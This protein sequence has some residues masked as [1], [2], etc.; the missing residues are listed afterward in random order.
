MVDV[1]NWFDYD[2][3]ARSD[4]KELNTIQLKNRDLLKRIMS[5][6]GFVN[7]PYEWWHW[8]YGDKYWGYVRGEDAM[9]GEIRFKM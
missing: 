7:Y 9:F 3:S 8:S 2:E 4:F 6:A 5:E 1:G